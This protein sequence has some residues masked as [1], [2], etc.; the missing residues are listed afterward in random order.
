MYLGIDIGGTF[1]DLVLM[2]EGGNIS[3]A[4]APTTPGELEKGVF[5]AVAV[6]AKAQGLGPEELL[7]RV[8]AFGHGTTQATN[9]LIERTG[10][11]TGLITTRGFGDTLALQRLMGFT[12]GIPVEHLGRY[13]RRRYPD[14]IVPRRLVRE[15][16]ERVD[17][18]GCVLVPLDEDS[19]RGA[20]RELI[21][22]GVQTF[23]VA[24]LWSFRNPAHEE[25]VGAIIREMAPDAFVSLSCQVSP[26]IGEYEPTATTVLNS[27]L[28]PK[29]ANY[30]DR[31]ENLLRDRGFRGK[32]NVLNSA[33]SVVPAREAAR[34]PVLLVA[35]GPAG[36]V[37]GSLQ[38]AQEIG[39][40]N[41]SP[42]TRAA[43][44]S[45]WRWWWTTSRW[46]PAPTKSA[47]IISTRRSSIFAPSA[48][49]VAPSRACKRVC[50][51]SDPT[52]PAPC[53][54]RS[55]MAAAASLRPSPTPIWCSA[56][57]TRTI[58]SAAA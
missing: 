46:C 31:I 29:V 25:R 40:S 55:A 43:P 11:T 27:Y 34:K 24:L 54:V 47:A 7:S 21:D 45:T 18:A 12:A 23:A 13:S 20:V 26:I 51:G 56:F 49:A 37:M 35:S 36:G 38:L 33:G 9:A 58:S 6:A 15:V 10:A 41:S 8:T 17:Q 16:R 22:A 48:P 5:D 14:P 32:F 42:P 30:L 3:T 53:R 19:A 50:C 4:K 44:A 1:T 28:A 2:D 57:S 39:H 52:V